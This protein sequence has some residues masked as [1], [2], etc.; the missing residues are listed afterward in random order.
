VAWF[1]AWVQATCAGKTDLAELA[2]SELERLGVR[3][4]A[5]PRRVAP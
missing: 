1:K 3:V 4:S 2:R 5:V